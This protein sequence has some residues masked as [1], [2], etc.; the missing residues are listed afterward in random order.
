VS[1]NLAHPHP[2]NTPIAADG[3]TLAAVLRKAAYAQL[4]GQFYGLLQVCAPLSVQ[5][6]HWGWHRSAGWAILASVFGIWALAQQRLEG[7]EDAG[8]LAPRV[9][10]AGRRMWRVVRTVTAVVGCSAA[11]VL[12]VEGFVR[13]L[14]FAFHCPGCAG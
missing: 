10:G 9:T 14:S 7:Y 5:L 6:W 4:P 2:S 11:A 13:L 8:E 12:A 1:T 3:E